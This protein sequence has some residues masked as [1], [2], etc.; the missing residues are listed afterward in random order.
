[1]SPLVNSLTALL[2]ASLSASGIT[3]YVAT[4]GNDSNPG[5]NIAQPF[6]TPQKAVTATL[7]PG[8]IIYIR[9]GNYA[10]SAK[11]SPGSSK[12]GA[13]GNPIKF[14]AYP[15]ELPVFDFSG[16]G[17][18]DKALDFRRNY[19]HVRGIEVRN[20]PDSGIFIG[21]LGNIIEGCVVRDSGND[22]I[23]LGSTTIKAT[24]ALILNCDS[25]RNYG[26]GDG[27]NGDG[28]GAKAGCGPGNVFIGC[29]AWNNADDGWDC[30]QNNEN[31]V[32]SNCWAFANGLNLWG[33]TGT[34][35][36]NG[37][38]FKLGGAG[39]TGR[40]TVKNSAAF[41]NTSKGFDHNNGVGAHTLHN[42]TGFRNGK[43]NFSFYDQPVNGN[44]DFRNNLSYLGSGGTNYIIA[45]S[46]QVSNSWQGFTPVAGDFASLD[47]TLALAPR[48]ADYSLPDNAF[49][50]LTTG[51]QF[52]DQG[53][54][55]GMPF[56]GAA[57]DLGAFEYSA[58]APPHG[59]LTLSA[60][61]WSNGLF[62]FTTGGLTAHGDIIVHA[63][64]DLTTWTPIHT[65]PPV[66]GS[67]L[68]TDSNSV[69]T[70]KRFYRTE[71]K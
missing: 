24:N 38:G 67:W 4:N 32:I 39:T 43:W 68:F 11:V 1:M 70:P 7:A 2:C 18:T 28:F 31:V 15:G 46:V 71:E 44:H 36:G 66:S 41:D 45:T 37:N 25:F 65:N 30:Y 60:P 5:T 34:W 22:G 20:A 13:A 64:N 17:T 29:R 50:R 47:A 10:L 6:A 53:I 56:N 61:A 23:I 16:M 69:T 3:Y 54:N 12:V 9:G 48:N 8:D 33:Y 26:G 55:V 51:S 52:V 40:H 62:Q 27:N 21:G 63:S 19:W 14:W 35:S 42:N 49:A 57:P 59:P 58:A